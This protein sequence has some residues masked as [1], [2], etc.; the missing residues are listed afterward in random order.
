[1]NGDLLDDAV[2]TSYH[3]LWDYSFYFGLI[4]SRAPG[5]WQKLSGLASRSKYVELADLQVLELAANAQPT[6]LVTG[7]GALHWSAAPHASATSAKLLVDADKTLRAALDLAFGP[8]EVVANGQQHDLDAND[9]FGA[10]LLSQSLS[11]L[12]FLDSSSEG[13]VLLEL[14]NHLSEAKEHAAH[15]ATV[16]LSIAKSALTPAEMRQVQMHL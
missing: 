3:D 8:V 10:Q 2:A 13:D 5:Y 7:L 16:G 12:R 1:M 9:A 4:S 15:D 11:E 6:D 14:A